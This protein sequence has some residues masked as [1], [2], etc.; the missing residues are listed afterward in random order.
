MLSDAS[1]SIAGMKSHP[2]MNLSTLI[3]A[4]A[5]PRR[6]ELLT[7]A[8]I[9][10]LVAPADVNEVAPP[11]LTPAE[12]A[13]LN[14]RNKAKHVAALYPDAV[15]LGAD[16]VVC[17]DEKVFGKPADLNEARQYLEALAGRKHHVITGVCLICSALRREKLFS[18]CTEVY[19]KS[20]TEEQISLYLSRVNTLDKAGAYAIQEHGDLIIDC[21]EGSYSNVVGL[22]M[23]VVCKELELWSADF[24]RP[25]S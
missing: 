25:K 11:Y 12:L 4:S 13:Q 10:F 9:E 19:F 1:R 6:R 20:L 2:N 8:G 22:P 5:S 24:S 7:E 17:L 15:A 21:I 3:L 23:E 18:A 14:A 16:T